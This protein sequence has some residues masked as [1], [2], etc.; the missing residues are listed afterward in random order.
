M[1]SCKTR[2]ALASLIGTLLAAT[3]GHAQYSA[4]VL[5]DNPIHYYRF[6]ESDPL[7]ETAADQGTPGG[8]N[9][10]FVGGVTLGN[11][12]FSAA[13]G[14]SLRLDGVEA[15]GTFVDLGLFHPGNSVSVEA[16][17]NLD[18]AANKAF[19]AAVARWDGSYEIDV[20]QGTGRAN[21]VVRN[22][23]N[24]FALAA[25]SRPIVRGQWHHLVGV[26]DGGVATIYLDGIQGT[27]VNIGGVLQN[28]GPVPDRVMVGATRDG[29]GGGSFNWLGGLD[30]VAIYDRALTLAEVEEHFTSAG[31]VIVP[32]LPPPTVVDLNRYAAPGNL[33]LG[34]PTFRRNVISAPFESARVTDG[35]YDPGDATNTWIGSTNVSAVGIDL[36]GSQTIGSIAISNANGAGNCCVNR[37]A[38]DY[39]LQYTTDAVV[40]DAGNWTD[41]GTVTRL[42]NTSRHRVRY[43]FSPVDATGIRVVTGSAAAQIAIDEIEVYAGGAPPADFQRTQTGGTF[44]PDNLAPA[45]T[46]FSQDMIAPPYNASRV[47][48]GFYGLDGAHQAWIGADVDSFV[49]LD[50][51][52]SH[53][54]N[55]IAFGS[56]NTNSIGGRV[57]GLYQVE[58]TT[59]P[60]PD[61]STPHSAWTPVGVFEINNG[62]LLRNLY[63]FPA[64]QATGVRIMVQ[65]YGGEIAIDEL[66][67]YAVPEPSSLVVAG[68][69]VLLPLARLA[70]KRRASQ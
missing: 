41:L 27:S 34:R 62:N 37:Y 45:A 5:G 31:G 60:D 33:A 32:P 44:L 11:P 40:S 68:I 19:H 16:W 15:P 57:N 7:F 50:L 47:N 43:A 12:S 23:V 8:N 36:G 39:T 21:F 14:S 26:F 64:V 24:A 2:I 70:R 63:E 49:G 30:E 1:H 51:N 6:E 59:V 29:N 54:I 58:V 55:R 48:D 13:L 17:I 22:D 46:A 65:A 56:D 20:N 28:A 53:L 52:G 35:L 9:G 67:V 4:V 42:S 25:S 66:E 18:P 69:A 10:Q 38:G 3:A 61:A